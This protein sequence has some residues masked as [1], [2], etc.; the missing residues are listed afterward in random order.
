MQLSLEQQPVGQ[1]VASQTQRPLTHS[2]PGG[3]SGV[4]VAFIT[5]GLVDDESPQPDHSSARHNK[6]RAAAVRALMRI[7]PQGFDAPHDT[8]IARRRN[9]RMGVLRGGEGTKCR[10]SHEST[11]GCDGTL[12]A[13]A[14]AR[15]FSTGN[16]A[17][18]RYRKWRMGEAEIEKRRWRAMS[19]VFKI[20]SSGCDPLQPAVALHTVLSPFGDLHFKT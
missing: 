8:R 2:W 1:L 14:A 11:L 9:E 12:G 17:A 7:P 3:Q 13:H 10:V 20:A 19:A 5:G 18:L 6:L 16:R 4:H 15:H